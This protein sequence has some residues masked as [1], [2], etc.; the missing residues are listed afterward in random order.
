MDRNFVG[1]V[2]DLFKILVQLFGEVS[3]Q[4]PNKSVQ[5]LVQISVQIVDRNFGP[6]RA[7]PYLIGPDPINRARPD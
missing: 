2:F 6:D 4:V 1:V 3:V 7:W 5:I